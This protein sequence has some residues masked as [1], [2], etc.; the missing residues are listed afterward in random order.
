[1]WLFDGSLFPKKAGSSASVM[2]KTKTEAVVNYNK[3][4]NEISSII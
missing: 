1:M 3:E 4:E 2:R